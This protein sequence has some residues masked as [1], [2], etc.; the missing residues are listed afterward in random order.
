M[1]IM[2]E[3][4]YEKILLTWGQNKGVGT[5]QLPN[6]L[7]PYNLLTNLLLKMYLK[8]ANRVIIM[9][10]NNDYEKQQCA[11]LFN[12]FVNNNNLKLENFNNCI[13]RKSLNNIKG[14]LLILLNVPNIFESYD[15]CYAI[16]NFKFRLFLFTESV[17][18]KQKQLL[19]SICPILES[20]IDKTLLVSSRLSSPVEERQIGVDIPCNTED[21]TFIKKAN[22]YLIINNRIFGSLQNMDKARVGD[23]INNISSIEYCTKLAYEN[24]WSSTLD[25]SIEMNRDIDKLY[26]PK[27]LQERAKVGYDVIRERNQRMSDNTFKLIKIWNIVKENLHKKILIINKRSEFATIVTNYINEKQG[28]T[29]C[30][31]FHNKLDAVPAIDDDYNIIYYKSGNKKG[32]PKMLGSEA[33]KSLYKKLFLNNKVNIL[34]CNSA[35]DK[36]LAGHVDIVIITSPQC[37]SI[38][39]YFYRLSEIQFSSPLQLYTLYCKDTTEERNLNNKELLK[40]QTVIKDVNNTELTVLNDGICIVY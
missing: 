7:S 15:I 2:N 22:E 31:S 12:N 38:K 27:A 9:L 34:S 10:V 23:K 17:T 39:N 25:M 1:I 28:Y 33:Q 29:I 8:N 13:K 24:G 18:N 19:D 21:Y 30:A 40:N 20:A 26:N 14:D 3:N 6:V 5:I 36:T 32:Q 16:N 35:V 11:K 37:E 4:I